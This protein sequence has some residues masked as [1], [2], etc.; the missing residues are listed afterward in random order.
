LFWGRGGEDPQT[1]TKGLGAFAPTG[2][3]FGGLGGIPPLPRWVWGLGGI[4]PL[5]L[6]LTPYPLPKPL[7]LW[8]GFLT[9]KQTKPKV[10]FPKQRFGFQNK[11]FPY[12][13]LIDGIAWVAHPFQ[14]PTLS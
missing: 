9:P 8:C 13:F 1:K 10:W 12:C 4:P 3:G 6:P 14:V 5:P 2:F 11:G 7:P